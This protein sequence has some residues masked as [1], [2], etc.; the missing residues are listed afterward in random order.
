MSIKNRFNLVFSLAALILLLSVIFGFYSSALDEQRTSIENRRVAS[1]SLAEEVHESSD[2]LTMLSRAFVVTN[3][4]LFEDYFNYLLQLRSGDIPY[5]ENYKLNFWVENIAAQIPVNEIDKSGIQSDLTARMLQLGFTQDEL[6]KIELAESYSNELARIEAVAMNAV[7]GFFDDGTGAFS[8]RGEPD[9]SFAIGLLFGEEYDRQKTLI[10]APLAEFVELINERTQEDLQAIR[11]RHKFIISI[12]ELLGFLGI[13]LILG[14]FFLLKSH[15]IGPILKLKEAAIYGLKSGS[16]DNFKDFQSRNDEI[17]E[18]SE[19]FLHLASELQRTEIWYKNIVESSADAILIVDSNGIIR[20]ANLSAHNMFGYTGD[21]LQGQSVDLLVPEKVRKNHPQFR[22][23]FITSG[24]SRPMGFAGLDLRGVRKDGTEFYIEVSLSNLP[25]G[26]SEVC[27]IIRDISG[28]VSQQKEIEK[29]NFLNDQA[30]SMTRSGVWQVP[31]DDSGWYISSPESVEIFGD[32]PREGYRY[33]IVEEWFKNVEAGDAVAAKATWENFTDAVEGK[34]PEYDSVYAYKRPVDGEIVWIH[35]LG[36]ILEDQDGNKIMYGV[37]QDITEQ[38]SQENQI[39]HS[40]QIAEEA[41]RAKSDF[42]ANMSHEIRTPM[43]AIIGMSHLALETELNPKQRNY[44]EKVKHAAENLLGII[45]DILDFSKIEAGKLNIDPVDFRLEDILEDLGSIVT[46][47]AE[48][49]GLEFLYNISPDIPTALVGDSLRLNQILTNLSNNAVKFTEEGEIVVGIEIEALSEDAVTLHFIV[50]D[51]GIGMTAEQQD[52]LFKSFSQADTSTTRKFGGTG[53]GLVISKQL[54]EM[55]GGEIWLESREGLGSTFHFKLPFGIQ[56]NPVARRAVLAEELHGLK[57]LVVDD[58]ASAR[59]IL[60]AMAK[61]FGLE[62]DTANNGKEALRIVVNAEAKGIPYDLIFMDWKM[63]AMDGIT[64]VKELENNV[65][66]SIPSIIM[67][68]AFGRQEAITDAEEKAVSTIKSVLSKPVTASKLLEAISEAMDLGIVV[69]TTDQSRNEKIDKAMEMLAGAK[70]LLVE[71]NEMNQEVAKE[72]LGNANMDVHLA[73]NG[74][75]AIRILET[76]RDFD[77]VLMDCQMPVMDGYE[78]TRE[79]RKMS[80]FKKIP[81]L[82]MTANA[83]AGDKEK[84]L[85]VGMNDHIP[86]PLNVEEMFTTIAKW[87]KPAKPASANDKGSDKPQKFEESRRLDFN[88]LPGINAKKGLATTMN[89]EELYGRLLK[90]FLES[91]TRFENEFFSYLKKND[92]DAATR[93]AHTLKG[94]AGNIGAEKIYKEAAVLEAGCKNDLNYDELVSLL[95][96]TSAAL[97]EVF[98]GLKPVFLADQESDEAQNTE[99]VMSDDE[100]QSSLNEVKA[101]LEDNDTE[102]SVLIE[103]LLSCGLSDSQKKLVSE[104][105]SAVSEYDFEKALEI[106]NK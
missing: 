74:L 29:A 25:S 78:A 40:R 27:A 43:N 51:T 69:S 60:S 83:M 56:K 8:I 13:I 1:I 96:N 59:E 16:F 9:Q 30:M 98:S 46:M 14:G 23:E 3:N 82:A 39:V 12:Q 15:V 58:N 19:S 26:E 64:C 28:R 21:S 44:I 100:F 17:S 20:S 91:Q 68:T 61:S 50:R 5:P 95:E 32:I 63:P 70:V 49:K 41:T 4:P 90:K 106:I 94:V 52:K 34:I 2:D 6:E 80:E 72:L 104:I 7:K 84:V 35:A 57:V 102:S 37:T 97:E 87:I 11:D 22:N 10:M 101:L 24:T 79:I 36:T 73:E 53:L 76:I 65:H 47:K 67:V 54:T 48:E 42:L 89:N 55:M 38:K 99:E 31:L 86:K 103:K 66:G 85:E 18:T 81:I 88:E 77:G 45:N 33:R 105:M 62:V 92:L 71:D 75:E 93:H